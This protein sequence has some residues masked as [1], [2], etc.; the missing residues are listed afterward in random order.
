M[1][2]WRAN[3]PA[4]PSQEN[5]CDFRPRESRGLSPPFRWNAM[6]HHLPKRMQN[7]LLSKALG[8][9]QERLTVAVQRHALACTPR[10]LSCSWAKRCDVLLAM[11]CLYSDLRMARALFAVLVGVTFLSSVSAAVY[12]DGGLRCT[13]CSTYTPGPTSD[14]GARA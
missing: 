5:R 3:R 7:A 4:S 1:I 6:E 12:V 14:S 13:S 8:L 2:L 9:A 10:Q 11:K